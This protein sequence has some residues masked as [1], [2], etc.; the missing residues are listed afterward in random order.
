ML[1]A[2]H[3]N[4]TALSWIALIVG[5]FLVYN[6]VTIS[7]VA[8]R[9]EIGTLRALGLTRGKVLLLFL[10][11]AAALAVRGH[12]AWAW[13]WRGCWPTRPYADLVHGAHVVYRRGLRAAGHEH[14]PRLDRRSRSACRCRCSP[15]RCRRSKPAAC[16]PTA[17]MRGHDMLEMRT[18]LRPGM[19]VA[20]ADPA[21]RRLRARAAAADRTPADVRLRIV[22]RDRHRRRVAGAGDHVRPRAPEPPDA[23]PPAWRRRA[24][25]AR[26]PHLGDSAPVD[27]GGGVVGQPVDDGRDRGD[28]RQLPR[29]GRLLG[30]ARR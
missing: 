29:H 9:Q 19:L 5:L 10:G 18:R 28:D 16:A 2:F 6:T 14:R 24:A 13:R 22:V 1:A 26:Q 4:L 23:A 21:G 17:A 25:R 20:A 7:V 11:E 15:R 30:R 12:R 8:R 3:A 27:F